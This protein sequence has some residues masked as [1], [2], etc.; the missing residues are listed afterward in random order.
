MLKVF[1]IYDSKA[2]AYLLPF[3][4][5]NTAVAIRSFSTGA[6]DK[7]SDFFRH[8]ADYTLFEIGIWDPS[9]GSWVANDIKKSLG[10]ALEF[11]EVTS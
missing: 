2:E 1:S 6:R 11:L 9:K 5:V 4:C 3:F 7:G 8:A 10:T